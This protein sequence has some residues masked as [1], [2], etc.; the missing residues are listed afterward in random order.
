MIAGISHLLP[1]SG[2]RDLT[3]D[4]QLEVNDCLDAASEW[5]AHRLPWQ[6]AARVG[7]I[8][9]HGRPSAPYTR[10]IAT[11][12]TSPRDPRRQCLADLIDHLLAVQGLTKTPH[13]LAT[14]RDLNDI[15]DAEEIVRRTG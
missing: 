13:G 1:R 6:E 10:F 11:V 3:P 5:A 14:Q 7:T 12:L 9:C 8:L 4:E 2:T 15:R